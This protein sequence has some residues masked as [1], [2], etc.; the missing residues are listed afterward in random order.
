ML[1]AALIMLPAFSFNKKDLLSAVNRDSTKDVTKILTQDPYLSTVRYDSEKNTI[2]M[3]ALK[4]KCNDKIIDLILDAGCSPDSKNAAGKTALMIACENEYGKKIVTK[5]VN[6]N[7][8]LRSLKA[9]RIL[10]KDNSGKTAFDYAKNNKAAY[11]AL[12]A[13]TPDPATLK[14]PEPDVVEEP[15]PEAQEPEVTEETQEEQSPEAA[16]EVPEVQP[17]EPKV[18]ESR[19]VTA[20]PEPEVPPVV[21]QT[22]P[23]VEPVPVVP[24]VP[25]VIPPVEE[26]ETQTQEKEPEPPAE[27]ESPTEPENQEISEPPA[28]EQPEPVEEKPAPVNETAQ[29]TN[30]VSVP[31]I[32]Y[33]DKNRPEYLF[34]E[35]EYDT[36]VL[37]SLSE[38]KVNVIKNPD[39]LDNAGRT[40]LMNAIIQNDIKLCYDL[41]YSGANA[42]AKDKDGWTP[43][44][45]ACRY[46]KTPDIIALLFEYDAKIN[47]STKFNLTVLD[48]AA[49]F[50]QNRETLTAVLTHAQNDK[51]ALQKSFITAL[52]QERPEEI[53]RQYLKFS[54]SV[55]TM[56]KGKTP[57][58][59]AAT[60]Y[61]NTDVI[62]LLLENGADPYII[63]SERKNAF[64]YAKENTKIVHD[65]VYWSLNVSSAEKR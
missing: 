44:M 33:Y 6:Y 58:M 32:N 28:V 56:Y 9:K 15:K 21:E 47:A 24:V 46:A 35:I 34:D 51:A 49:S 38:S 37:D 2:L 18:P 61:E 39:T 53:I 22:A 40:R 13:I 54:V 65:S 30:A 63:S 42:N 59:Y 23:V 3:I 16:E 57:L 27:H 52:K 12:N 50:C 48:I 17:E 64:S 20:E 5:I 4:N 25:V 41:L 55:N 14:T 29:I 45:Y 60:Y 7:L 8:L 10:Q 26:P 1:A 19:Q 31:Q 11:E 43:L 62:K 36:S